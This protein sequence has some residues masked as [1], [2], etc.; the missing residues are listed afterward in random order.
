MLHDNRQ[1]VREGV[2]ISP[3]PRQ[4]GAKVHGRDGMVEFVQ[5]LTDCLQFGECVSELG[6][7]LA[8][9]S[10]IGHAEEGAWR[11]PTLLV[12]AEPHRSKISPLYTFGDDGRRTMDSGSA[13]PELPRVKACPSCGWAMYREPD[14]D[15]ERRT[16]YCCSN[17]AC[18]REERAA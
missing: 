3:K 17:R 18:E 1:G 13:R 8:E 9:H 6:A 5:P 10:F 4:F 16:V 15:D 12:A 7:D 14:P 2:E 11:V